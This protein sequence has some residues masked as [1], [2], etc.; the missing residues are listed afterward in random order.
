[1][2]YSGNRQ[3]ARRRIARDGR[4][5]ADGRTLTHRHRRNQLRGG[6]NEHLVFDHRTILVRAIVIASDGTGADVHFA[7][8][9]GITHITEMVH[10]AAGA[11]LAVFDFDE[12]PDMRIRS[13][14]R[15]R[16]NTREGSN[17]AICPD[18]R[19]FNVGKGLDS[20]TGRDRDIFQ[21]A[22]CA[23]GDVITQRYLAFE[24]TIDVND[25]ISATT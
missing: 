2:F 17:A 16:A 19:F 23:D 8:Y 15:A 14:S 21:H 12:I 25:N 10:L 4:S 13:Q 11:Y 9:R 6:T 18:L 22:V 20:G 1:M 3:L 7:A 5:R 24:Y